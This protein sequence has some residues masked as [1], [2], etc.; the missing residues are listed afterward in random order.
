MQ[1]IVSWEI[2][3]EKEERKKKEKVP[4]GY[5]GSFSLTSSF[6]NHREEEEEKGEK[7]EQE[8]VDGEKG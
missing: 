7:E 1:L 2:K 4:L 5:L 3:T 6:F 8:E